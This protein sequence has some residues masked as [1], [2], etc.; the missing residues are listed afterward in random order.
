MSPDENGDATPTDRGGG[1]SAPSQQVRAWLSSRGL[2][3]LERLTSRLRITEYEAAFL[4]G[5]P[6]RFGAPDIYLLDEWERQAATGA[7]LQLPWRSR[8]LLAC[9][10]ALYT[11]LEE[12]L[13]ATQAQVDAWLCT[14]I[15]SA[16]FCGRSP[17]AYALADR[18]ATIRATREYLERR[19]GERL[20]APGR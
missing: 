19:L 18:G 5:A 4:A 15:D 2:L 14:R 16:P 12:R 11:L 9:L 6:I 8:T 7:V 17:L 1:G 13:G 20:G 10:G 3:A